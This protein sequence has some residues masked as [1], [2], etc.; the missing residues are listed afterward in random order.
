VT[1][2]SGTL[3]L[4]AKARKGVPQLM[5]LEIWSAGTMPSPFR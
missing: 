1:I 4:V 3:E 2:T 5:G